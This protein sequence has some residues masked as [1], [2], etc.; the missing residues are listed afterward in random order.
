MDRFSAE[1]KTNVT[2]SEDGNVE[3]LQPQLTYDALKEYNERYPEPTAEEYQTLPKTMGYAPYA[4]YCICLIEFAER[5]SYYGIKDRLGNFV[6]LP[7]PDGGNGAGAPRSGTQDNAGALGLGLQVASAVS[8][9]LTFMA[10]LTPLLG[11]YLADKSWGRVKT[12]WWGVWIGAVSHIILIIAAIPSVISGGK[13]LAPTIISIICLAFGSGFIKPNLLPVLYDQFPHKRDVVETREDG[14]KVIIVKEA[15]LERMTLVF[16]WAI[17]VGAFLSV[18][19][20]YS[21]KRIGFWLAFLVPGI[22]YFLMVPVLMLLAPRLRKEAP[23][24]ISLLEEAGKVLGFAL[25]GNFI[26]RVKKGSFWEYPK[27]SSIAAR[28]EGAKL[29]VVNRK[30]NKKINWTDQFVEDVRITFDACK[31]FLFFVIYNINDGGIGSL[32]NSQST[33]M[34]TNGVPNDLINNFNP[35]TIIILIPILDYGVYPLLRKFKIEYR[36]VYRIFTGF[37]LAAISQAAGAIIQWKVYQTSPCGYHATEC[38]IGTGVSPITVW[39][40]C[41]LYILQASSECF[42]MTA[43]YEIA[44]AR[45]PDSMKGVVMALF[46]FTQSLSAAISEACTA[47]LTDPHLIWPFV[48]CCIAGVLSAFW[49][50]YLYRDLHIV[51]DKERVEKEEK[52]RQEYLAY[53]ANEKDT[54]S[55]VLVGKPEDALHVVS[56]QASMQD[57]TEVTSNVAAVISKR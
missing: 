27:P 16:Y 32:Q 10:Y 30:G 49:F 12:I 36:P 34:T 9:L 14:S 8:L 1:K 21:A 50:L 4:T 3:E 57:L 33:A 20:S 11:G 53:T 41:V 31:I 26:A 55:D 28:G 29:E 13:A 25:K 40:E 23:S 19:T 51:M 39:V 5:A 46:L 17:N 24:G 38:D 47:S 54:D 37:M 44:Y 52:I 45:A 2:V 56:E 7:L 35:L 18:A 22:I 15:S 43:A 6:Q 42:A 48:A